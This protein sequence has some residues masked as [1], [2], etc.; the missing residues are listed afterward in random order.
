M[1][2]EFENVLIFLHG[3]EQSK[4]HSQKVL[5]T[6]L[7]WQIFKR[8]KIII[9]SRK[10]FSYKNSHSFLYKRQELYESRQMLHRLL[11]SLSTKCVKII[12]YS[13]GACMALDIALTYHKPIHVMCISGFIM[14][15]K[16]ME[17]YTLNNSNNCIWI[18]HGKKD[19]VVPYD[20]MKQ[21]FEKIHVYK[22][23]LLHNSNHWGFWNKKNV[24]Q[25][26]GLYMK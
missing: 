21:S 9:P 2:K 23:L 6:I 20:Q 4:S 25:F 14:N 11:D 15:L 5:K 17:T 12:G 22:K 16:G 3:Y 10:W 18:L 24:V 19:T 26:V 7:P 13:Q 8:A 1:K